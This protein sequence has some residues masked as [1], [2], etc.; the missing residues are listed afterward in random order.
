MNEQTQQRITN[1]NKDA[2]ELDR[3]A[4]GLTDPARDAERVNLR[5]AAMRARREAE[6][7]RLGV[8]VVD[9]PFDRGGGP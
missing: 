8:S 2:Q 5:L 6:D 4:D 1:L 3:R 9:G 7:L